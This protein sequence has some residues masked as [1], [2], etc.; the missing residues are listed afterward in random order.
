[1]NRLLSW[2]E[3]PIGGIIFEPG[4]GQR[5]VTGGWRTYTPVHAPD[6]CVNCLRC[7]ILCPDSAVLVESGRVVGFD[8]DHCKGLRNLRPGMP[9]QVSRNR[10]E[11]RQ[12][13]A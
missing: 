13:A 9:A 10:N 5:Y 1:M 12:V 8:L 4:S 6:R 11:A 7:W 2:R 3:M